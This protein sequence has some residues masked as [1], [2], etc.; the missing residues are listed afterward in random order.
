[1]KLHRPARTRVQIVRISAILAVIVAL[2]AGIFGW[3]S[4][5]AGRPAAGRVATAPGSSSPSRVDD[6]T[7]AGGRRLAFRPYEPMD[8]SGYEVIL[9]ALEPWEP[10]A[11]LEKISESWRQPGHKLIAKLEG[12]LESAR[13]AGDHRKVAAMLM[14]KSLLFNSEGE[15]ERSY[16]VLRE[17]RSL[18]EGVDS[19]A[20]EFLYTIIYF[21]G[22]AALRRGENENCIMCRGESSCILP[23]APAAVHT[24]PAGSRLAIHHFTEYLEQFPNDLGARWLLNLAHM[25]LGEHPEKVDPRFLLSL[26]RF[27]NSEFGI[28][29]FRDAGHRAGVDRFNQSGGAIMEDFDNDGWLDL[30]VSSYDPLQR[31]AVYWNKGNGVFDE[32]GESA[33]VASQLGG[34]YCVQT[35]YNNDGR[36]DVFIPRGAWLPL[37]VRPSLLR[38]NGDRTFTDVTH[39]AGL[40]D[41]VNSASAGWADY[42]NDGWLDLFICCERQPNR[43]YHNLGNGK[44]EEVSA[45]A[46]L[47][48]PTQHLHGCKGSAWVDFDN[49][50]C[51]D[52]FLNNLRG[53]AELYRNNRNGTFSNVTE[54]MS[55][56]GPYHGFSCWAWDYDNDGWL[57]I[58]ATCFDRTLAD[59]VK[60]LLGQPHSQSSNRLFR[61]VEGKR[62]EDNTKDTGLDQ[63]FSCMGSNYGDFDSDGFLDF[64]LG[65]G[66]PSIATLVPN[67]MFKNVAGLRF[68]EITGSSGTGH[69]Q[70]GHAV[71]CGDWDRDGDLDLF[72]Q[73]GGAVNGDRYHNVL[74]QNPGQGNH[75]LTV[76]LI[77]RKTNRAAIGARIKVVT[78]GEKRLT[79]RRHVSSGSSFGANPLEQHIGLAS[80]DRIAVLEVQWPTSGTTQ[81]F[82]DIPADQAIEVTEFALSYR[83]IY[84]NAIPPSE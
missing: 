39:E 50:N 28:G 26:D 30:V 64:Y 17:A 29:K 53:V 2:A 73:T 77:G 55:I 21:Q 36:M 15:P 63:V 5:F 65:T 84:R 79:I 31:L 47:R 58:F 52:L 38:N 66:E 41:P 74:F 14:T 18:V 19:V 42:D 82:R 61:N 72:V 80:A 13:R 11:S 4:P 6:S 51:P 57:D 60:G 8:A 7:R 20:C 24:N 44:F 76:K 56:Q 49:D 78:A 40:M 22:V 45:R 35:D 75:S 68:A 70:K 23:I 46:G 37:P 81:V 33:G 3:Y 9:A 12:T 48:D 27:R 1:M 10:G 59:V 54:E 25:T 62:F 69:L 83:P 34:L 71:A 32:R 67:R 16:E 43:L